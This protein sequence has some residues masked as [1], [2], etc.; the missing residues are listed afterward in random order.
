MIRTRPGSDGFRIISDQVGGCCEPLEIL[1]R[2]SPCLIR[3]RQSGIGPAPVLAREE[4]PGLINRTTQPLVSST[5]RPFAS[6]TTTHP[7]FT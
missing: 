2:K 7:K 4:R 1:G 5:T 3:S 6:W